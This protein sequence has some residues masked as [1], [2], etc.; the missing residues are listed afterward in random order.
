MD[1]IDPEKMVSLKTVLFFGLDKTENV[2]ENNSFYTTFKT[3]NECYQNIQ[4]RN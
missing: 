3:F 2:G 1:S 4:C